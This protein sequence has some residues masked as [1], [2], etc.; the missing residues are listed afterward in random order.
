M[1][2][3]GLAGFFVT[4]LAL[5]GTS[6]GVGAHRTERVAAF[7]FRA[8]MTKKEVRSVSGVAD[9]TTRHCWIYFALKPKPHPSRIRICFRHGRVSFIR[10]VVYG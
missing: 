8:G 9:R 6:C 10:V 3:R 4:V 2:R 5:L 1:R 7:Q